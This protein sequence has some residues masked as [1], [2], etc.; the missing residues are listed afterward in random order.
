M[1]IL[2]LCLHLDLNPKEGGD[3]TLTEK[4]FL[5]FIFSKLSVCMIFFAY[6]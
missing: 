5:L 4:Y 6:I 3:Q 1:F 2:F